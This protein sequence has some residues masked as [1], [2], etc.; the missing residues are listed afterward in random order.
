LLQELA[1]LDAQV[2]P[3]ADRKSELLMQ[4]QSPG[5]YQNNA[6]RAATFDEIHKLDQF[7]ALRDSLGRALRGLQD[8]LARETPRET[9]MPA[10]L[11]HVDELRAELEQLGFIAA[12]KDARDLGD[13]VICLTLVGHSGARIGAVE[14]LACMYRALAE[15]HRLDAEI[16]GEWHDEKQDRA[17]LL[18][19]GLGAFALLKQEAGLHQV[20][21]RTRAK[22]P[23]S[24]HEVIQEDREVVRVETLPAGV[25]PD[26]KFRQ[27]VKATVTALRPARS[28]LLEKADLKV[29]LFHEASLRS[30]ELWTSGPRE[31]G[32]ER[33]MVLFHAQIS[34][35]AAGENVRTLVVRHYDLGISARVKDLRT[36][37]TTHRVDRVLKGHLDA[38]LLPRGAD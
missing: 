36:G 9:E 27:G 34:A 5:F 14:K 28:R 25:Q 10:L 17:Y 33:I 16:L 19:S 32:L 26:K 11:D 8:R 12:C 1:A 7:L 13:A 20:D 22:K 21:H 31:P 15:R 2:R 29:S 30:L 24:G 35:P 37:R 3:L 4:T 38:L 23:R 18:V 6:V